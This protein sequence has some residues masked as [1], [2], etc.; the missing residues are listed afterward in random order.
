[1][2]EHRRLLH[3]LRGE[4]VRYGYL[5]VAFGGEGIAWLVRNSVGRQNKKKDGCRLPLE[6]IDADGIP[7]L[8]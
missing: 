3:E 6:R 2:N 1:M 7:I 4:P 5:S 8:A